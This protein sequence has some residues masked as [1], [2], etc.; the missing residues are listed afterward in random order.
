M[1][2]YWETDDSVYDIGPMPWGDGIVD[3]EDVE[4]L[5]EYIGKDVIDPTCI[6]HWALDETEGEITHDRAGDN[7]GTVMGAALWRPNTGMIAGALEFDG[8]TSVVADCVLDPSEDPFSVL[9]WVNGGAPGQVVIS[10]VDGANWLGSDLT[11][12]CLMTELKGAG[13]DSRTLCSDT[14]VTDG[15]W[16]R[17]TLVCNGDARSLYVDDILAAQDTQA[18]GSAGCSGGLNIGC[19]KDMA[20]GSFFSGLIDDVRIYNRAVRP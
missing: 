15:S 13:R 4:V 8:A 17:I 2:D 12:G 20:P 7:H 9:A 11:N 3:I 5:A 10:Q 16:H 6:A 1:A 19:D 14:I 18:G